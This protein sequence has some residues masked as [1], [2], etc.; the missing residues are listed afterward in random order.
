LVI[1]HHLCPRD[2]LA[3][4]ENRFDK[5][6]ANILLQDAPAPLAKVTDILGI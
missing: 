4:G 5:A 1:D 6:A 2:P 3:S